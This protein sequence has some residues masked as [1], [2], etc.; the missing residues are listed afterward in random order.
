MAIQRRLSPP[1]HKEQCKAEDAEIRLFRWLAL[2][3]M[4]DVVDLGVEVN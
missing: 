1:F 3:D 2:Y 4:V